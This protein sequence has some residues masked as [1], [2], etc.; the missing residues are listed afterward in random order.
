MTWFHYPNYGTSLQVVALVRSIEKLGYSVE[1]I[2]YLPHGKIVTKSNYKNPVFYITKIKKKISNLHLRTVIDDYRIAAFQRFLDKEILLTPLCRTESELFTLNNQLDTFVC[3]SDQIWA[4]S[5]FDPKYFLNFAQEPSRIIAYA[6]SIGLP[7]IEDVYVR[8]RMRECVER[9]QHLSVREAQGQEIIRE[10]CNKE[11]VVVLDPTLLLSSDEWDAM[12]VK[13]ED[14]N[15]YILC[16]FLGNNKQSWQHVNKLSEE[17]GL[18]V[19]VIP[20]FAQN[21]KRGFHVVN[22]VGP[23]EFLGLVS[24]ADFICTDSFHGTVFSILYEKPFYT[25]ERFSNKDR[26]SQNSRIYNLLNTAGLED[27]LIKDKTKLNGDPLNCKFQDAKRRLE[28]EKKK[29]INYLENALKK[30]TA[31]V[32][33]PQ[34]P[35]KITNTCCGC[36]ICEN[37]CNQRAIEIKRNEDGFL[38]AFIDQDQCIGCGLCKKVCPYCGETSTEIDKNAHKLFMV[39]SKQLDVLQLS[40]SGGAGYEISKLLCEQGYDVVGCTYD[41]ER[42]E[43]VH[44]FVPAKEIKKLYIFQGS[45]YIQSNSADA[46]KDVVRNSGK[47]VV[48]GTPCQIAG[49]DRLLKLKGKRDKFVL[50]DLICHGV[51]SQNLWIKYLKEG[52]KKHGYGLM[53]EVTFRYKLKGWR[54]MYIHI[55]GHERVYTCLDRKDLFYRFYLLGHCYA[56]VCYE[57]RYRTNSAA[58]IRIGDYWGHRYEKVKDGVSMVITMTRTGK[59][60]LQQLQIENRIEF[61]RMDCNEYWTVQYPQNPIKPVFYENL[62]RGLKEESISLETIADQYCKEFEFLQKLNRKYSNLRGVYRKL[63]KTK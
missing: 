27:R 28:S 55:E 59:S 21:L 10:L 60:V 26:N 1:V 39:R 37:I 36:G 9:F 34:P 31:S 33:V 47:A 16:Y 7:K 48:F 6:P 11:A 40:S 35:Y 14:K 32:V 29:S 2:K 51:P 13:T 15:P 30:S 44:Q 49:M 42:S 53:P 52:S 23:A 63:R 43:A 8:N 19:K 5:C 20:V 4:P 41:K 22:G 24:N 50:V 54:E 61:Q 57:C 58:D 17:T 56:P 38:N 12:K 3:G 46:F 62:M 18:P 25:Y 45:K